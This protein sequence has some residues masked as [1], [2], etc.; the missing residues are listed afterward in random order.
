MLIE[1][2]RELLSSYVPADARERSYLVRMHELAAGGAPFDRKNFGPGHF[3]ASAFVLDP[4]HESLLL[5]LHRKLGLWLQPGG[6]FDPADEGAFAA[7]CREVVEE[8]GIRELSPLGD[9]ERIFDVDIHLIP[10]RND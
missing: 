6:H 2:F 5:I 10:E 8:T 9:H 4:E 3:T 1:P 7:A